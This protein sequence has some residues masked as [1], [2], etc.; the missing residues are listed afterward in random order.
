MHSDSHG[1]ILPT[2]L[3]DF[4]DITE[5]CREDLR[6]DESCGVEHGS[7]AEQCTK[8]SSKTSTSLNT[9]VGLQVATKRGPTF[10]ISFLP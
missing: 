1:K 7:P 8:P 6:S 4:Q 2:F 3:G 9:V 10:T 5:G